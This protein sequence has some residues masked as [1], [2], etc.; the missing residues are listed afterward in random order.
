MQMNT[1]RIN[2]RNAIKTIGA[3][4]L[5]CTLPGTGQCK[6]SPKDTRPNIIVIM[7]D[8]MGISDLGCYG[9]EIS[10]PN[11]NR[12]AKEG[13]R[14]TQFYNT[15]RCCPSR[16][17]ILTG[18][19]SHQAGIGHMVD[20]R[21][22]EAYRGR[23]NERCATIAELLRPAGYRTLLSGKWHV[24]EDVPYWPLQRGFET[25]YGLISGACNYFKLDKGRS[26]AR[27]NERITD[28]GDNFYMTDAITDSAVEQIEKYGRG[29][30]PFFQYVAYTAPHWPLHAWPED[31]EK[32]RGRYN[33]GW[34]HLRKE[35]HQRMIEMGLVNPNWPLTPRDTHAD[36]W[37]DAPHKEWEAMRM[38]VYA[39]QI[40][41]MDQGIGKIMKKLKETGTE[42]NTLIMFLADNGGC[43][44]SR[45]ENDPKIMPGPRETFMS[46]GLAWANASNTP[47]R[48]FK[49]DTHEGGTSTAF[50]ARW[51]KKIESGSLT[52]QVGH[53]IDILPT[54]LDAADVSY[55][56]EVDGRELTPVAGKSYLPVLLGKQ[57]DGHSEI[58]WEHVGNRAVRQ[59]N[60]KLVSNRPGNWE[61][62]DLEADRTE[63]ND[64]IEKHPNKAQE[65][66]GLYE[67]WFNRVGAVPYDELPPKATPTPV[68]G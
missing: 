25:Y 68:A 41:R 24:G 53:I 5:A 17:S 48:R 7:C 2:R 57:R 64:L 21:G 30:A 4:A 43:A 44:E 59:G 16:A 37:E 26:F 9:S 56:N 62:Y 36:A 60:W 55:P 67:A 50:I 31:I 49:K 40:D 61:L 18:L 45:K 38:A 13:M 14:S 27:D 33:G 28:L 39:A 42:E 35:R 1:N 63:L 58:Y 51:P 54:C 8:D 6:E 46:Y 19:Y 66:A 47:F 65:L 52:H 23:L 11:L 10:T 22:L 34:D 29:D 20:D 3:G 15:A 32:Y 12:L